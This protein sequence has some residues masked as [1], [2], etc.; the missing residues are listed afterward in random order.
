MREQAI[1]KQAPAS[2][3]PLKQKP[4]DEIAPPLFAI[5]NPLD[6]I[7]H[8]PRHPTPLPKRNINKPLILALVQQRNDVPVHPAMV[9]K[10]LLNGNSKRRPDKAK[11]VPRIAQTRRAKILPRAPQG[12]HRL[13]LILIQIHGDETT[14]DAHDEAFEGEGV[15]VVALVK[16]RDAGVE[17]KD[18]ERGGEVAE[19]L[20]LVPRLAHD[21]RL[22]EVKCEKLVL[23]DSLF[24]SGILGFALRNHALAILLPRGPQRPVVHNIGTDDGEDPWGE[25]EKL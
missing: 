24:R 11:N 20:D 7:R 23:G 3:H 13:V 22:H 8:N 5:V 19:E 10:L 18:V 14:E 4:T 6:A 12:A 1:Q 2:N 16:L 17:Q 15:N 9:E 21:G 25:A